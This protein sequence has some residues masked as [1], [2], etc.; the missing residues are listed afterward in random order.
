MNH[1]VS[2][3][4]A[5]IAGILAAISY[6]GTDA[7]LAW[8][9][10]R[11]DVTIT[12]TDDI[13]GSS[14]SQHWKQTVR[15]GL[16][17]YWNK[18]QIDDEKKTKTISY[19]SDNCTGDFCDN[20]KDAGRTIVTCLSIGL[21]CILAGQILMCIRWN[22]QRSATKSLTRK[23]ATVFFCLCAIVF[24]IVCWTEW[25]DQCH[26]KLLDYYDDAYGDDYGDAFKNGTHVDAG[27]ALT[28]IASLL[29]L[30]VMLNECCITHGY[31]ALPGV[32]AAEPPADV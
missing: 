10:T 5:A 16:Y 4:F 24:F 17:E 28:L 30:T 18:L 1:C 2:I 7:D 26:K 3:S 21:G 15:W 22:D 23:G 13:T 12:A 11:I 32:D 8:S 9:K 20:C 14:Y 6:A 31:E 25:Y 19:D 29:M 27:F